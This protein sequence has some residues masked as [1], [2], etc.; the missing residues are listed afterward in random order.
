MYFT[1]LDIKGRGGSGGSDGGSDG[2][3]GSNGEGRSDGGRGSD[4][5]GGGGNGGGGPL[6]STMG[7]RRPGVG[8]CCRPWALVWA[9]TCRLWVVELLLGAGRC[10]R[11]GAE[12]SVVGGGARSRAVHLRGWGAVVC[13]RV[14]CGCWVVVCGRGA[15]SCVVW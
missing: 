7:A 9:P 8:G 10:S 2:R 14:V 6:L 4:G 1:I 11:V 13:G 3:G 15:V 5:G 12:L